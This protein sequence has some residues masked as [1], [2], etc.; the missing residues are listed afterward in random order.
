M[1]LQMYVKALF[2]NELLKYK[3]A[4]YLRHIYNVSLKR[5]FFPNAAVAQELER[6]MY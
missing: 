6:V 5:D 3:S 2:K 1:F 4:F